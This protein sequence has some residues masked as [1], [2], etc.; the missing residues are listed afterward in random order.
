VGKREKS[1]SREDRGLKWKGKKNHSGEGASKGKGWDETRKNQA[2][3]A[4][5]LKNRQR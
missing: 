3:A 2:W 1:W 5:K 4:V